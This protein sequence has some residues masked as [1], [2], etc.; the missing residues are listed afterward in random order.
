MNK[1]IV[2][3]KRS[4]Q[5]ERLG[6]VIV[7]IDGI[8]SIS[9]EKERHYGSPKIKEYACVEMH[10]HGFAVCESFNEIMKKIEE[11]QAEKCAN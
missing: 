9:E 6:R 4:R 11:A 2:L 3:T 10:G 8:I 1:F 5:G 7:S